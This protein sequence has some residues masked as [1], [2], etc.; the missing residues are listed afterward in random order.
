MDRFNPARRLPVAVLG[1]LL[2]VPGPAEAHRLHGYH[3]PL[4]EYW[5]PSLGICQGHPYDGAWGRH[6]RAR[7]P[8]RTRSPI[9]QSAAPSV[10][11]HTQVVSRSR[12][13][14]RAGIV[15]RY[16]VRTSVE[17]RYGTRQSP[18]SGMTWASAGAQN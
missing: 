16:V 11:T 1:L 2:F 12:T 18:P 4:G 6:A 13:V 5:R 7:E 3:C 15:V 14:S 10:S 9:V 17:E 8:L